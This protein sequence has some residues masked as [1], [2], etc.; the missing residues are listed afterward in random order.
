VFALRLIPGKKLRSELGVNFSLRPMR[1]AARS[2][3]GVH[4]FET[5][6]AAD[7]KRCVHH[8]GQLRGTKPAK[9]SINSA[10]KAAN[11]RAL[12]FV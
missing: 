7:S 10:G 1:A 9:I 6:A 5:I 2:K 3:N 11:A 4:E 8:R 12:A